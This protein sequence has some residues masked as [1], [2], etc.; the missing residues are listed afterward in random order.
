MPAPG[1]PY[2]PLLALPKK[3]MEM[4][5]AYTSVSDAFFTAYDPPKTLVVAAVMVPDITNVHATSPVVPTPGQ[6]LDVGASKTADLSQASSVSVKSQIVPQPGK[7]TDPGSDPGQGLRSHQPQSGS[8]QQ[9]TG[10]ETLDDPGKQSGTV[11]DPRMASR[12]STLKH[13]KPTNQVIAGLDPERASGDQ[14][15]RMES[16]LAPRPQSTLII[17]PNKLPNTILTS[18]P[19]ESQQ[20]PEGSPPIENDAGPP[21]RSVLSSGASDFPEVYITAVDNAIVTDASDVLGKTDNAA[22]AP[23]VMP[24]GQSNSVKG[25]DPIVHLSDLESILATS[26][27]GHASQAVS[28]GASIHGGTMVVGPA[29]ITIS[30]TAISLSPAY[31]IYLEGTPYLLSTPSPPPKKTPVNEAAAFPLQNGA[32][33]HGTTLTAGASAI[34]VMETPISLDVW[35][36]SILGD[37]VTKVRESPAFTATDSPESVNSRPSDTTQ[38][39]AAA[40]IGTQIDPTPSR[41]A[42]AVMVNGVSVFLDSAGELMVS[43]ETVGFAGSDGSSGNL[44]V[45]GL[46]TA[47][48]PADSALTTLQSSSPSGPDRNPS[49]GHTFTSIAQGAKSGLLSKLIV[50]AVGMVIVWSRT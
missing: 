31:S 37:G 25:G 23:R 45:G 20:M 44:I 42:P 4:D 3:V 29:A 50:T 27:G 21:A 32:L 24:T 22:T 38:A 48:P 39:I 33:I 35:G 19:F 17:G 12:L 10:P 8:K 1:E 46:Q 43:S 2:R 16:A 34:N 7:A 26:L 49:D 9:G 40:T 28:T 41:S 18:L 13:A 6:G 11:Q 30:E 36:N 5:P 14:M 15:S 47:G